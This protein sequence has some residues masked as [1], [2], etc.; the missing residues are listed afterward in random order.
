MYQEKS[1]TPEKKPSWI[2]PT[3][4]LVAMLLIGAIVLG[5]MVIGSIFNGGGAA[6]QSCTPG[7]PGSPLT[8]AI[9]AS[10]TTLAAPKALHDEQIRNAQ[11]IDRI[12]AEL[13]L[14]GVASK[15]AIIAAMGEST[16]L[17]LNYG[18]EGQGVM[19]PDGSPTTSKGLFQQQTPGWGT[20]EHV[21]NPEYATTSFLLGANHKGTTQG[22]VT[23]PGWQTGEITQVIHKVQSNANPNHYAASYASA[24]AIIDEA[25]IDVDRDADE[26]KQAAWGGT[27]VNL[28]ADDDDAQTVAVS[29]GCTVLVGVGVPGTSASS[30]GDTYPWEHLSPPPGVYNVDPMNFY[31]GECTSYA[32]WKVNEV[33]GGTA[34]KIIFNNTYGG[35]QK[36]NGAEWKAAWEAAGW[37]VSNTPQV[38]SVAWWAANGAEGIGSAGHVGWVDE[39]TDDGKVII[40]EYNNSY[41]APPGHKYNRRTV[42]IDASEV[43]AYLYVPESS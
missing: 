24:N 26:D 16:L 1:R 40:S 17:N 14:P 4:A 9:T 2:L 31:Y 35:H 7:S 15:I 36:G 30:E 13:G 3:L 43:N 20:V 21:T 29:T 34:E 11:T 33:M 41:Y 27:S 37:K 8:G 22:L 10:D 6:S 19:N 23:V 32:S 28:A 25:G 42:A 12:A 39:V 38:D 5:M 18:D